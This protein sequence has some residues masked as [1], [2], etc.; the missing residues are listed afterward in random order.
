MNRL[1]IRPYAKMASLTVSNGSLFEIGDT[2]SMF[3]TKTTW[4][5]WAQKVKFFRRFRLIR[6]AMD[7]KYPPQSVREDF[8]I[9]GISGSTL[10]I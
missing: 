3:T 5:V 4:P 7:W 1:V 6:K 9:T 2:I 8:K 10:E